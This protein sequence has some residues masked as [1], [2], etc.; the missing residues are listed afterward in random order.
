MASR[1]RQR[2]V[3]DKMM[4]NCL[5]HKG[6]HMPERGCKR[7][8]G[9]HVDG[10]GW[11]PIN[12]FLS[13]VNGD[14]FGRTARN[15][16]GTAE[17]RK[18]GWGKHSTHYSCALPTRNERDWN[19]NLDDVLWVALTSDKDRYQIMCIVCPTT[20][21]SVPY[22]FR[23][24]QGHSLP[25][26]DTM[27]TS[28]RLFKIG[29]PT[30]ASSSSTTP[31]VFH[32][33]MFDYI[34]SAVRHTTVSAVTGILSKGL[35]NDYSYEGAAGG[36]TAIMLNAF[37]P[38]DECENLHDQR[39]SGDVHVSIDVP[40]WWRWYGRH[41]NT[42]TGVRLFITSCGVLVFS[43]VDPNLPIVISTR[44]FRRV[45]LKYDVNYYH[46]DEDQTGSDVPGYGRNWY[47]VWQ[48]GLVDHCDPPLDQVVEGVTYHYSLLPRLEEIPTP[49]MGFRDVTVMGSGFLESRAP[50]ILD[51]ERMTNAEIT[52]ICW[53]HPAEYAE[54]QLE[55]IRRV[56][57][58]VKSLLED[59]GIQN[60]PLEE[61]PAEIFL[62]AKCVFVACPH[63]WYTKG[64]IAPVRVGQFMC[65]NNCG[66]AVR[67]TPHGDVAGHVD[68]LRA[69]ALI[70]EDTI[71]KG[72]RPKNIGKH[73]MESRNR[74]ALTI[75]TIKYGQKWDTKLMSKD[76]QCL[77]RGLAWSA[78]GGTWGY[79]RPYQ[80]CP[81]DSDN[82]ENP[83]YEWED[84]FPPR[85]S[86]M[87][88]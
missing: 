36:R 78:A 38:G 88:Q 24:R 9:R 10:G 30:G 57:S 40:Y 86:F 8:H 76:R 70:Y 49:H 87:V 6:M 31:P 48:A 85:F 37:G 69:R 64:V 19:V 15:M 12:T 23:A 45:M 77:P 65:L 47:Q 2:R 35:R 5:R 73:I 60:I 11:T 33:D 56:V 58:M 14:G 53:E 68:C 13:W 18:T 84:L 55:A 74:R 72:K 4:T 42:V 61:I 50:W 44:C 80:V 41:A 39:K 71:F 46:V 43:N 79:P 20:K 51:S 52:S 82:T 59:R 21:V 28:L 54:Y 62:R 16:Q 63:C 22:W 27:R 67:W 29:T 25:F 3:L 1:R 17:K 83:G 66:H 75:P 81:W 34:G 32:C 26:I 7:N